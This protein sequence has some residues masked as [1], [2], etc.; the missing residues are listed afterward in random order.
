MLFAVNP[1]A[2]VSHPDLSVLQ[3]VQ[4]PCPSVQ[5]GTHYPLAFLIVPV[6]QVLQVVE[7]SHSK[8]PGL[9]IVH[10]VSSDKVQV[11]PPVSVL[12]KVPL[13]NLHYSSPPGIHLTF[14]ILM[15]PAIHL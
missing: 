13:F 8:H 7:F 10:G 14:P 1:E 5:V 15:V 4:F 6:L 2:Q 11:A 3:V 12:A 9:E